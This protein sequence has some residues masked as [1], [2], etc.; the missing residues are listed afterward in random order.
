MYPADNG[1]G[2]KNELAEFAADQIAWILGR[3][4]FS[5]T[6]MHGFGKNN[7]PVISALFGHGT[8]K[9]G[10]ANG[11]TGKKGNGDGSGIDWKTTDG[12]NEWRWI[13]QWIPHSGW[14]LVAASAMAQ[15]PVVQVHPN[16]HSRR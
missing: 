14:F 12:G 15:A 9:G 1:W 6:F 3:N 8:N 11:V 10:I 7:P 4:P 5:V 2:V 16:S 13:E